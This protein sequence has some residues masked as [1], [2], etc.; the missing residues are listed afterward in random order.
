MVKGC[1]FG[2]S[3]HFIYFTGITNNFQLVIFDNAGRFDLWIGMW[4]YECCYYP[5]F[6]SGALDI[7]AQICRTPIPRPRYLARR[8]FHDPAG[9]TVIDH[10]MV[11]VFQAPVAAL[12]SRWS[13]FIS[14]CKAII[15]ALFRALQHLG[16]R[17]AAPGEFTARLFKR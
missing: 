8:I 5:A 3:S 2:N 1:F 9:D 15:E 16:C 11:A 6:G 10:G 12:A 17:I 14:M 4:P 7:C 13:N